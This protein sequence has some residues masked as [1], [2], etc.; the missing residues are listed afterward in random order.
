MFDYLTIVWLSDE[1]Y[2]FVWLSDE[3]CPFV[4]I[5]W[6]KMS[7]CLIV[8]WACLIVWLSDGLSILIENI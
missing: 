6:W 4:T 3:F 8:W 2:P 7:D 1:I 5:V